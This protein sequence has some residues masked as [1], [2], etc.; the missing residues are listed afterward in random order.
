LPYLQ[1]GYE[2]LIVRPAQAIE[3]LNGYLES[4]LTVDD[5]KAIYHKPLYKAP[6][7][8]WVDGCKAVMIYVKNYNQR[9]DAVAVRK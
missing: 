9:V 5:L 7:S 6:R 2:Q 4:T 8:S 1:I 3:K